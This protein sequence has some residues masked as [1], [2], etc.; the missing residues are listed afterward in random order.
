MWELKQ[1]TQ[2]ASSHACDMGIKRPRAKQSGIHTRRISFKKGLMG[3]GTDEVPGATPEESVSCVLG[4][5]N[6]CCC[7]CCWAG[8]P[9][10]PK[11]G[12]LA[13][14]NN[15]GAEAG[16]EEAPNTLGVLKLNAV[17]D[18]GAPKRPAIWNCISICMICHVWKSSTRRWWSLSL[19]R[20]MQI[21]LSKDLAYKEHAGEATGLRRCRD[22]ECDAS[23]NL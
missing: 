7:C 20:V 16:C 12:E 19:L 8:W 10:V 9:K 11:P 21:A 18:A 23:A 14:P 3:A 13:A 5:P 1:S 15:E 6:G 2:L 4:P 22:V 17:E